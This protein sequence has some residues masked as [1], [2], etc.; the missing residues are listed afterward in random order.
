[1]NSQKMA[2]IAYCFYIKYLLYIILVEIYEES[3]A[4]QRYVVRKGRSVLK[5]FNHKGTLR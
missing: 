3:P 1:M 5:V 2:E 4:S